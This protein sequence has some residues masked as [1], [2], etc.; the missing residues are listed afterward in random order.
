MKGSGQCVDVK[1]RSATGCSKPQQRHLR[2]KRLSSD[3]TKASSLDG[4]AAFH[5][6]QV[7]LQRPEIG[8]AIAGGKEDALMVSPPPDKVI[9][10]FRDKTTCVSGYS[11]ETVSAK[12]HNAPIC[13]SAPTCWWLSPT[14]SV[15]LTRSPFAHAG[16]QPGLA[17]S[18]RLARP[19]PSVHRVGI[20]IV[21]S[22]SSIPSPLMP[23]AYASATASRP[24]PQDWRSGG[25][26]LLSCRT[27]SF[28]TA[29]RFIPA[30][31]Q[32]DLSPSFFTPSGRSAPSPF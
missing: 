20:P 2:W 27:L 4:H 21:H 22:R 23:R 3:S 18:P 7:L 17:L 11:E 13:G 28:P 6:C 15:R 12:G 14:A 9:S 25:S 1:A 16:S 32:P 10:H 8:S 24:P 5:G 31:G 26:L 30:L 29:C 19:S